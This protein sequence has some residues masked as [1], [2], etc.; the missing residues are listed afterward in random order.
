ML[1]WPGENDLEVSRK[2]RGGGSESPDTRDVEHKLAGTG[3]SLSYMVPKVEKEYNPDFIV[4]KCNYIA[5]S[6]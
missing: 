2:T 3:C 1:N 4:L 6:I 5:K